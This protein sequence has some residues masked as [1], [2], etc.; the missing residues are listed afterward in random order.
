MKITFD[1]ITGTDEIY[2]DCL[3]AICGDTKGKSMIDLCCNKAPH[4]PLLGFEKRAYV[5]IID[6]KLDHSEEQQFFIKGDVLHHSFDVDVSICSDGIEHL[7]EEE[8]IT[9][10]QKMI[11]SSK[12]QIIFTP[13]DPWMMS[14]KPS[15]EDPEG[16][17]SVW[18]PD[19]FIKN[20][21]AVLSFPKYH[22][23]L[24]IGAFFAWR[25]DEIE[26]DSLRVSRELASKAWTQTGVLQFLKQKH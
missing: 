23:T 17:H 13:S 3:L 26:L 15:F 1:N 22:P 4:T 24:G 18:N 19:D 21:W 5:D 10:L 20:G 9:L 11:K 6:R 12:R 14:D 25:C 8:G 16:H 2:M 7:S